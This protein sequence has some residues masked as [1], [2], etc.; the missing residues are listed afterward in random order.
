MKK[1]SV[2][3]ALRKVKIVNLSNANKLYGGNDTETNPTDTCD[4]DAGIS[5]TT[6]QMTTDDKTNTNNYIP[7]RTCNTLSPQGVCI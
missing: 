6:T 3:L 5:N 7:S 4:C 2:I 1:R